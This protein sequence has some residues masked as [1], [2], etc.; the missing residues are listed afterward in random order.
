MDLHL[1]LLAGKKAAGDWHG[2]IF[3]SICLYFVNMFTPTDIL[4][5]LKHN[6]MELITDPVAI[7][8]GLMYVFLLFGV[9]FRTATAVLKFYYTLKNKGANGD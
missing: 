1:V 9:V 8:H 5:K 4:E 6:L 7:G 3:D 2:A